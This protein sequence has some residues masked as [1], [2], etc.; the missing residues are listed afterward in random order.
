M[1]YQRI[2]NQIIQKAISENR[3]KT[4]NNYYERHHI[5]P[6]S[7][8][9]SNSKDNLVLLTAKEHFICHYLLVKIHKNHTLFYQKMLRAFIMLSTKNTRQGDRYVNSRLY[10]KIKNECYGKNGKLTKE[11]ASFYGKTHSEETRTKL[12]ESKLGEL[13]PA[14]GK[15]PWNKNKT[16]YTD[17]RVKA[18]GE[19]LSKRIKDSPRPPLSKST[20][21]H[22]SKIAKENNLGKIKTEEHKKNLSKSMKEFL[23]TE[24]GIEQ[25]R[26]KWLK[27]KAATTGVKKEIVRCPHCGKEGGKPIMH[28][29]HFE[30]CKK[31]E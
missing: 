1:D 22:L 31:N 3:V 17:S 23:K 13:N 10:D 12:S 26:I 11:N 25:H 7:L 30:N 18:Y 2:Y 20:R 6:K 4:K 9:G 8:G 5:I 19:T 29:H 24:E 21:E 14:Y 28:R 27:A 16:K 15:E